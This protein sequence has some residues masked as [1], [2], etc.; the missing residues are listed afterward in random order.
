MLKVG[1]TGGIGSGKTTVCQ[2]FEK[3]GVPVYYADKRGKELMEDDKD[4]AT[5]IS[6]EF[7][8]TIYTDG[9]LNKD[10]LAHIVFNDEEKL[11]KLN[12]LVHPV[13]FSDSSSWNDILARKGY[14]YTLR[15]SALLIES[16]SYRLL[17]KIIVVSTPEED[18]IKRVMERDGATA[19]Q[20][21]ARIRAQMPDEQKVKYADY[22]I[23][24]DAIMELV[25]Q[26]TKI[27][28]DLMNI[29]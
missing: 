23:F 10:V 14:A 8:S 6:R 9:K 18:R 21:M 24:N 16:G 3:L 20:V 17:D 15:E 26:V 28:V 25:T 12:D 29:N 22:I 1:I 7:G 2:I 27:H 11:L 13:V 4:L 5:A 19:E